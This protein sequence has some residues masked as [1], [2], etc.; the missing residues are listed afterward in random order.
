[1]VLTFLLL[2]LSNVIYYFSKIKHWKLFRKNLHIFMCVLQGIFP[3]QVLNSCF[4]HLLHWQA[5][6]VPLAPPQKCNMLLLIRENTQS[7]KLRRKYT[8]KL[9]MAISEHWIF[10]SS[11]SFYF[12]KTFQTFLLSILM[13]K[14]YSFL[15]L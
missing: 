3:T 15:K 6:S 13:V 11:P 1:M 14:I 4:L 2:I 12:L 9:K 8:I 5:D 10:S 7:Q